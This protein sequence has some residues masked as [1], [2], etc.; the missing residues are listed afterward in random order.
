M[1]ISD[2]AHEY[3]K[4]LVEAMNLSND[5]LLFAFQSAV[6][7]KAIGGLDDL[8]QT[9]LGILFDELDRRLDEAK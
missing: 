3:Q 1:T 4:M 5:D 8:G 9:R 2:S 6:S 7:I